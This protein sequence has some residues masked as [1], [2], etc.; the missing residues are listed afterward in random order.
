MTPDEAVGQFVELRLLPPGSDYARS[1]VLDVLRAVALRAQADETRR[2]AGIARN[3][4]QGETG[5]HYGEET[6]KK[7][8]RTGGL[9]Q[10]NVARRG[11]R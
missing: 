10:N 3:I 8:L 11:R 4:T 6:A 5:M 2:C 7:I 9:E 1:A